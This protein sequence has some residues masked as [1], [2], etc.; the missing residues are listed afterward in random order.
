M[1]AGEGGSEAGAGDKGSGK[2]K[3]PGGKG[4]ARAEVVSE[5]KVFGDGWAS[6]QLGGAGVKTIEGWADAVGLDLRLR[7]QVKNGT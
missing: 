3:S 4:G 7:W 5:A 6:R 2:G 1:A